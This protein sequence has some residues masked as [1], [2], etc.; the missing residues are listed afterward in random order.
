VVAGIVVTLLVVLFGHDVSKAAHGALGP[1]KSE[2]RSF[3]VLAND[4][5][6]EQNSFDGRL[7]SL[8]SKGATLRR[9]VF[10]ARLNQ[11]AQQLPVWTTQANLLRGPVLA[12]HVNGVLQQITLERVA[13]Y[14][15]LLGNVARTLSLP[16][17]FASSVSVK[18]PAAVLVATS[19][20]WGTKR[21]SLAGE[22]G[23][24]YLDQLS[25]VSAVYFSSN[26]LT[27]LTQSS[28]LALVRGVGIAAVRVSP[29]PLPTHR[30]V[31]V[32][33]PT[34][35]VTIGISVVNAAYDI[36]PVT[37]SFRVTPLNN[38]GTP[39]A[40]TM[41]VTLGALGAHGFVPTVLHTKP[42]ERARIVVTLS[43]APSAKGMISTETFVL[44]VSP[45]GI[46]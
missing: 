41:R 33:P 9:P 40:Q 34:S 12:H 15:V 2:N 7:A 37:L 45:S 32:I 17:S 6:G 36:Q 18:D 4:L 28:S 38:L 24:V 3:S 23:H 5:I 46:P 10:A 21:F 13:A 42:R 8:L 1:R 29:A 35:A 19:K 11:L 25:T 43:G 30:G 22:P 26:G 14:Q 16:W 39:T 31:L 20:L 27:N 44:K